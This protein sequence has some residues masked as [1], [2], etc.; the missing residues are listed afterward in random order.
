MHRYGREDFIRAVM[1]NRFEWNA[2]RLGRRSVSNYARLIRNRVSRLKLDLGHERV[3]GPEGREMISLLLRAGNVSP[4]GGT[5]SPRELMESAMGSGRYPIFTCS[6]GEP[7]CAGVFRD[8]LVIHEGERVLWKAWYA[9]GRKIY[10]FNRTQYRN[11]ILERC[12]EGIKWAQSTSRG[13][14]GPYEDLAALERLHFDA[15]DPDL[16]FPSLNPEW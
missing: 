1:T 8:V 14:F 16:T 13:L 12:A 9:R 5:I 10:V 2:R 7:G 11:E 4:W 15:S 6:C 3:H